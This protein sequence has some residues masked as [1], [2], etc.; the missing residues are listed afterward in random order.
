MSAY[1]KDL[2]IIQLDEQSSLKGVKARVLNAFLE[3]IM[4]F[5]FEF[6][7]KKPGS[8]PRQFEDRV[9]L[10]KDADERVALEMAEDQFQKFLNT[11][12]RLIRS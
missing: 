2:C 8:K 6:Q 7:F 11:V 5:R 9:A 4:C 12:T 1:S 10:P 3:G